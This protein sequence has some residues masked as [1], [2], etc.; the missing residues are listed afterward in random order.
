MR[1]IDAR[2][3]TLCKVTSVIR[4]RP[5]A[6][7]LSDAGIVV[8]PCWTWYIADNFLA[9]IRNGFDFAAI[10]HCTQHEDAFVANFTTIVAYAIAVVPFTLKRKETGNF[11]RIIHETRGRS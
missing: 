6:V 2:P 7:G 1:A 8:G 11:R 10:R 5:G 3:P 9:H 4:L